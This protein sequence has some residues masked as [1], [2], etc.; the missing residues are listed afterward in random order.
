MP[1]RAPLPNFASEAEERAF[2]DEADSAAYVDWSAARPVTFPEL[3]ATTQTVSLRLP[4]RVLDQ[5]K[6]LAHRR[7]VSHTELLRLIVAE[8][9]E[10]ELSS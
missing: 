3:R 2:W 9:M 10:A 8:R 6:V 7:G 4:E 5:V 1:D